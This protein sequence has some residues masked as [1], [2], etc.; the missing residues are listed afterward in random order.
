MPVSD[1]KQALISPLPHAVFSVSAYQ[2]DAMPA[3]SEAEVAFAGR[4]NAGKS[5]ALN[6]LTAQRGLAHTSKTPG[7]TQSVNFFRVGDDA[8]FLVDLPGYGYAAV[9]RDH[10]AVWES[11]IS[12]YIA[13]PSVRGFIVLMDVRHSFTA[14]DRTLLSWLMPQRR[15]CHILLTKAD[16]LSPRQASSALRDAES[17]ARQA[18]IECRIQL[19]SARSGQGADQAR[20]VIAGWLGLK[21][22]KKPPVKGE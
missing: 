18:N 1:T 10:K 19:F 14:L 3:V 8:R 15:A 2:L 21:G 9:A 20:D 16:K 4:S 11:L 7:R 22:N 5:S 12:A 6:T 13:R 17:K